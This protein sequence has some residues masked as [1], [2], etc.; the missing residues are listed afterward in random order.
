MQEAIVTTIITSFCLLIGNIIVAKV[1]ADKTRALQESDQKQMKQE[2]SE[3]KDRVN[4]HNNYAIEI[5]LIK[6]DISYIKEQIN[7]FK[8]GINK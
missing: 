8:G 5:P 3:L 2:L 1:N 4:E 7:E 6:K